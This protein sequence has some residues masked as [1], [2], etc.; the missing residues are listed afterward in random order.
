[1]AQLKLTNLQKVYPNGFEAVHGINL[2][3]ADGEFMVLVGPSGCAKSTTLRMVAGLEGISGGTISIGNKVVNTLSPGNRGIAMVFQ[4]YALYPHMKV[5]K[6]LSFGLRLARKPK[7]E[8]ELLQLKLP[9]FSKLRIYWS[10]FQK[11]CLADKRSVLRWAGHSSRSQRFSCL[12]NLC[13]IWMQNCGH[14]CALELPICIGDF[15]KRGVRQP[16]FT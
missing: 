15:A 4:N 9:E 2:E 1:M 16:L 10:A 8:I 5:K 11:N 14:Q 7:A 6:N 13:R 3:V 12:M